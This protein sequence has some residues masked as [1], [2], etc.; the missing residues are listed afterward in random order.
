MYTIS[1]NDVNQVYPEVLGLLKSVGVVE[2]SRNGDVLTIPEPVM[3]T[4]RNPLNRVLINPKRKANPFFHLFEAMWMLCGR[5]DVEYVA[6]FNPRMREYAVDDGRLEGAYG[7]RWV[8][9]FSVDQ[10][11]VIIHELKSNPSSRQVVLTMWDP[12][13]DLGTDSKDKPCNTHVYFRV[14]NGKLNMT[15]CNRSND[16]VW[17]ACGANVV[18]MS[19]LQEFISCA[20]GIPVGVYNQFSNNM[21]FYINM[22]GAARHMQ[23]EVTHPYPF[24]SPHI[25]LFEDKNHEKFIRDLDLWMETGEIPDNKFIDYVAAPMMSIWEGI[26]RGYSK[27][28]LI[29]RCA[30]VAAPDWRAA[31]LMYVEQNVEQKN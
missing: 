12:L 20:T 8:S 6:Q 2:K 21:H 23:T 18:H 14:F 29:N 1:R 22:P 16:V 19:F 7:Y 31:C 26:K 13:A 30:R 4:Y 15:V 17:G 27:S 5:E 10:L 28:S 25:P 11:D 3:L 9:N 24:S